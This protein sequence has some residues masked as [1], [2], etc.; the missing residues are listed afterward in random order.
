[1]DKVHKQDSVYLTTIQVTGGVTDKP[2]SPNMGN[3][4]FRILGE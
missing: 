1:M 3:M 2:I 4:K